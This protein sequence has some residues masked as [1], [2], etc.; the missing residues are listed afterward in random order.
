MMG[1]GDGY[2]KLFPGSTRERNEKE[3]KKVKERH[4]GMGVCWVK[5]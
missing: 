2:K 4:D 5:I 1:S 3:K